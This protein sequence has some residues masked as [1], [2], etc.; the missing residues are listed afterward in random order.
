MS[1]ALGL[2]SITTACSGDKITGFGGLVSNPQDVYQEKPDHNVHL[3]HR[4][5]APVMCSRGPVSKP[6]CAPGLKLAHNT[7]SRLRAHVICCKGLLSKPQGEPGSKPI[8]IYSFSIPGYWFGTHIRCS[9][10]HETKPQCK[11]GPAHNIHFLIPCYWL[12]AHVICC[13]GLLSKPQVNRVQNQSQCT[14]SPFPGIGLE[15]I[16]CALGAWCRT[17]M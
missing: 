11:P 7:F 4:L 10:G 12:G 8:T 16:S 5:E 3:C 15:L 2:V 17:T 14:V 6:Q 9:G 1:C 13:W